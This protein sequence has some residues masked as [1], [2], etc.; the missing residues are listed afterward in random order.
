MKNEVQGRETKMRVDI[1]GTPFWVS[2][3]HVQHPFPVWDPALQKM[4][5]AQTMCWVTDE[6]FR[7]V[8]TGAAFCSVQDIFS[9]REGRKISLERALAHTG[10]TREQRRKF[11]EKAFPGWGQEK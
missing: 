11:W 4:I 9:K 8:G 3:E 2:F 5:R 6:G 10:F 7:D 1:D